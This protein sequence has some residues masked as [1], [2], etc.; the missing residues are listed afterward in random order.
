MSCFNMPPGVSPSDIPGCRPED[1]AWEA[2][3]EEISGECRELGLSDQDAALAWRLGV[4]ALQ[5]ARDNGGGF[6]HD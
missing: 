5:A 2:V 6:P 1:E 4:A 3:W